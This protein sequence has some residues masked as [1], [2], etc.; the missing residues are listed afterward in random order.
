M[1]WSEEGI[2]VAV[3]RH[4]ET[5][6]IAENLTRG[7]GRTLGLV[8]GGRSRALRPL[9]Q[10]G[11]SVMATWRARLED[12]LG[13]FTVELSSARAAWLMHEPF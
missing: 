5:S 12:Q 9:L 10:A 6:A 8:K 7:H 4:G 11:N 2:V 1:H 13:V 3:R